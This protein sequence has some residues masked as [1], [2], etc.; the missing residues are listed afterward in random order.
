MSTNE[1]AAIDAGGTANRATGATANAPGR[2]PETEHGRRLAQVIAD[3]RWHRVITLI[4][5]SAVGMLAGKLFF[6]SEIV[7][8]VPPNAD[9]RLEYQRSQADEGAFSAWAMYFATLLGNV[10][11]ANA[12]FVAKT[13]GDSL[14]PAIYQNVM[15]AISAQVNNIKLDNL[16]LTYVAD[17]VRVDVNKKCAWVTGWLTT[18]NA[19]GQAQREQRTYEF[20]F[21]VQN[22][23][24]MLVGM[25]AYT[26]EPKPDGSPPAKA[27]AQNTPQ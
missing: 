24:P 8:V 23:R 13:V 22:Y 9:A 18:T 3:N 25:Q 2:N 12:E 11:P 15:K 14:A 5:V 6:Q 21:S 1:T 19:R 17:K 26:G 4:V 20:Y 27:V 10:S 7:V 16:T